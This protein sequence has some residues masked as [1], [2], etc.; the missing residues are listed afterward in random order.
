[1]AKATVAKEGQVAE[2]R[3][4]RCSRE[5]VTVVCQ[6]NGGDCPKPLPPNPGQIRCPH[7]GA[8]RICIGGI[9]VRIP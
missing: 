9:L 1:M 7:G 8:S 6:F 5:I 3:D 2:N 4:P